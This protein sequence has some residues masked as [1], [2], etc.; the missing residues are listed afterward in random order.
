MK[1]TKRLIFEPLN[2]ENYLKIY[3]MFQ[4]DNSTFVDERFKK[5]T[6][7]K[8]Y[9]KYQMEYARYSRKRGGFDWLFRLKTNNHYAGILHFYD[10]NREIYEGKYLNYTC[11]IGFATVIPY[12]RKGYTKE[13]VNQLLKFIFTNFDMEKVISN[14][15][16][17]NYAAIMLFSKLNFN[18]YNSSYTNDD[19]YL[20]FEISKEYFYK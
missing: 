7:L 20:F 2:E 13:A 11:S 15:H 17:K 9:L 5:K 18:Q 10:I 16:K 19:Q 3:Q 4:K 1:P 12:R 8:E 6:K 14:T